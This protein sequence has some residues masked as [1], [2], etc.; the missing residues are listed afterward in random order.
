MG[1]VHVH[2]GSG[3]WR[4]R[5]AHPEQPDRQARGHCGCTFA[6][7]ELATAVSL[8]AQPLAC[9]VG[10]LLIVG[11]GVCHW[12]QWGY[13]AAAFAGLIAYHET[14]SKAAAHIRTASPLRVLPS[15]RATAYGSAS[16]RA[17]S[18][19]SKVDWLIN[20]NSNVFLKVLV[21]GIVD[22]MS[23]W[24]SSADEQKRQQGDPQ[25]RQQVVRC[26]SPLLDCI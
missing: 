24:A 15:E 6:P 16:C 1:S 5:C 7:P 13:I 20:F 18:R 25:K 26:K 21:R 22:H 17:A 4:A 14:V 23:V 19:S 3:M 8:L 2:E 12:K 10:W 11:R 9:C